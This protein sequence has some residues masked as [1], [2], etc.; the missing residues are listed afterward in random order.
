MSDDRQEPSDGQPDD[1]TRAIPPSGGTPDETAPLGRAP[2]GPARAPDETAPLGRAPDE[3]A[4][5]G[6]TPDETAPIGRAPDETAPMDRAA[7]GPAVP[8]DATAPLPPPQR[9]GAAAWSGRAEV[10]SVRPGVDREL[11]G[12]DWYADERPGR[13]WWL[14][15]LWGILL[16]LL[17]ALIGGGFWLASQGLDGDGPAPVSPSP[18]TGAPRTTAS[19]SPTTTSPSPPPTTSA[20]PAQVPV[21]PLVGLPEAAARAALDGLDLGYQVEYRPS[22]QPP[23]TVIE[24]DPEAGELVAAGDEVRLV[25]AEASP[26]PSPTTGEPT[27]EPTVTASPTD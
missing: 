15:I 2:D 27:T 1:R 17:L 4:P 19:P 25:V 20:A 23:G 12:G 3:T 6:R 5:L 10:P 16:L 8:A 24:T 14:P 13:P 11:A 26:S 21:P 18:T 7:G 22:D 9:A